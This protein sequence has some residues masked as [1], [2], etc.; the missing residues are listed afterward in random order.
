MGMY[1]ILSI[2]MWNIVQSDSQVGTFAVF[3]A[4][5]SDHFPPFLLDPDRGHGMFSTSHSVETFQN[6]LTSAVFPIGSLKDRAP[7]YF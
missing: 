2:R 7:N 6:T 5:S 3:L 1:F 4:F